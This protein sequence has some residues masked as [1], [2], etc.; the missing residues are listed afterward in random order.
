MHNACNSTMLSRQNE[1]Y[2]CLVFELRASSGYALYEELRTV[3]IGLNERNKTGAF[4]PSSN[5][6]LMSNHGAKT[7]CI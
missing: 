2:I 7:T 1:K 5:N 4:C 6:E 3:T